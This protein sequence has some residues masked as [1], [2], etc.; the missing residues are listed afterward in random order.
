MIVALA[1]GAGSNFTFNPFKSAET[2]TGYI[3]RIS[4]GDIGYDTMDYNSIFAI[5]IFLFVITLVLNFIS[6]III[7]RY[8]EI[9]D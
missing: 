7:S 3:A 6:Q 5:G 9:Y 1:A 8:R 4:G 2:M